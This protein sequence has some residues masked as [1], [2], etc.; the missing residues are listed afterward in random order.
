MDQKVSKDIKFNKKYS[1]YIGSNTVITKKCSKHHFF[2]KGA[3][4]SSLLRLPHSL[5]IQ[6]L[7]HDLGKQNIQEFRD[8]S[9]HRD[10]LALLP[11][12]GARINVLGR[13]K[14]CK[15]NDLM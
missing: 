13:K 1:V 5:S 7:L 11:S 2:S 4:L 8:H 9:Q 15:S 10:L 3:L 6:L 14:N 12:T